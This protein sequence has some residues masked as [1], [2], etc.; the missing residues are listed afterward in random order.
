MTMRLLKVVAIALLA[1]PWTGSSAEVT[2]A[3]GDRLLQSE[4]KQQQIQRTTQRVGDQLS[5]IISEFERNGIAGEDVKV[6]RAIR[7]VLGRLS[8][9]EMTQVITLLQQAQKAGD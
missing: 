8:E 7:M 3:R 2:T 1:L 6:L 5:S 4:L 9:K